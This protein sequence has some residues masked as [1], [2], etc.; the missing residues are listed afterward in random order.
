MVALVLVAGTLDLTSAKRAALAS[1]LAFNAGSVEVLIL[2]VVAE[3]VAEV[4]GEARVLALVVVAL[5]DMRPWK[6]AALA[7]SLSFMSPLGLAVVS[8][9][10]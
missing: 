2:A 10:K 5:V 3:L 9:I 4:D 1:S 8:I 7:S 6:R